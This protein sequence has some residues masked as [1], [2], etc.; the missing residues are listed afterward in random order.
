[1]AT[2]YIGSKI[3]LISKAGIRYQGILYTIDTKE[4]TVA[5]AKVRSFGTEDRPTDRFVPPRDEVFEYIIFRGSDI[6]DLTVCEPPAAPGSEAFADPAIVETSQKP[7]SPAKQDNTPPAAYSQFG[8]PPTQSASNQSSH[9]V[10]NSAPGAVSRPDASSDTLGSEN[11]VHHPSNHS[12]SAQQHG[13]YQQHRGTERQNSGGSHRGGGVGRGRGGYRGAPRGT[14][15]RGGP[16]G[17]GRGGPN[18]R[19]KFDS[20]F[21]FETS[22][23]QFNKEDIERELKE[24][25]T[26]S[27]SPDAEVNGEKPPAVVDSDEDEPEYYNK[28]KSFFDNI[29]CEA[30]DRASGKSIRPNWR[31]E[32]K[33]NTE[34]F[35]QPNIRRGGYYRGGHRG[36]RG[37]GGGGYNNY[38]GGHNQ[39]GGYNNYNNYNN[40][41]AGQQ[42]GGGYQQREFHQN[43]REYQQRDYHQRDGG[44]GGSYHRGGGGGYRGSRGGGDRG[45]GQRRQ[46]QGWVDYDFNYKAAGLDTKQVA[47]ES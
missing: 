16:R 45:R 30:S 18:N 7:Q 31:E 11:D 41:E 38:R 37:G 44:Q 21:D 10:T 42:G 33:V 47:T 40:R 3:S 43:Q 23:Q 24:K 35:G 4:S 26:I 5:L 2:P 1:M 46:N 8:P 32:R 20:E 19:L 29:G 27:C 13:Q 22:N 9:A 14:A 28:T 36:Y 15:V 6:K 39:R 34:T 12:H 25:L 17:R